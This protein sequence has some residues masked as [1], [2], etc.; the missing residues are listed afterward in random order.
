MGKHTVAAHTRSGETTLG[1]IIICG[2]D[3]LDSVVQWFEGVRRRG[4]RRRWVCGSQRSSSEVFSCVMLL[5]RTEEFVPVRIRARD[6][7]L[8]W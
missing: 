4:S 6:L 8:Q 1:E 5:T 7:V 2:A 3:P